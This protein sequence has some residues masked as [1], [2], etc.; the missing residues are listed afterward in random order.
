MTNDAYRDD[1]EKEEKREK[2]DDKKNSVA[3]K[4][5]TSKSKAN[6]ILCWLCS[7]LLGVCCVMLISA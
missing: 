5:T 1:R 7:T 2:K 4:A 6:R 3:F